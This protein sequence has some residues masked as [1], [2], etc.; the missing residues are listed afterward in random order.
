MFT[1][2]PIILLFFITVLLCPLN[3]YG[4]DGASNSG[5]DNQKHVLFKGFVGVGET[6]R[7]AKQNG[8]FMSIFCGKNI[9]FDKIFT[10]QNGKFEV[11]IQSSAVNDLEECKNGINICFE[12]KDPSGKCKN[13]IIQLDNVRIDGKSK[14]VPLVFAKVDSSDCLIFLQKEEDDAENNF[15]V[16]FETQFVKING[17]E[18]HILKEHGI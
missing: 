8:L 16:D 18:A 5:D 3:V 17:A 15:Q 2:Y 14:K 10:D 11:Q 13:I 9:V 1:K 7:P 6:N 12:R 4:M